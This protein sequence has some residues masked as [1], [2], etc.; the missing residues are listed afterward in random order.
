MKTIVGNKRLK[1]SKRSY[2]LKHI[3]KKK[4]FIIQNQHEKKNTEIK[5]I[6]KTEPKQES[7]KSKTISENKSVENLNTSIHILIIDLIMK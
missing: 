7:I 2:H 6:A 3:Q 5:P 1:G 4:E